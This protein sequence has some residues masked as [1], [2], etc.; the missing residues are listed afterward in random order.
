MSSQPQATTTDF[1]ISVGGFPESEYRVALFKIIEKQGLS[2]VGNT[3]NS[4]ARDYRSI[5]R[6][7]VAYV[8]LL[9][10]KYGPIPEVSALN[11][12]RLSLTELE[13][14]EA[15]KLNR[16]V[17]LFIS[18]GETGKGDFETDPEKRKKLEALRV[19]AKQLKT[20][21]GR[22]HVSFRGLDDFEKK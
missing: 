5:I 11:P 2:F 12:D 6:D 8:G 1:R 21:A 22:F 17:V 18:E 13:F 10:Q 4:D 7:G 19:R 15:M 14:N 16:P 3:P 9:G 20:D